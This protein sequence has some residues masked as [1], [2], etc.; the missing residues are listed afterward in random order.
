MLENVNIMCAFMIIS[1][2]G[3]NWTVVTILI[4]NRNGDSICCDL[5][6]DLPISAV[7]HMGWLI[8]LAFCCTL[9]LSSPFTDQ[10]YRWLL[11]AIR[12]CVADVTAFIVTM[13]YWFRMT[14]A[15]GK[16]P[17]KR[18]GAGEGEILNANS[19]DNFHPNPLRSAHFASGYC[20]AICCVSSL[21]NYTAKQTWSL[22]QMPS[23]SLCP[24]NSTLLGFFS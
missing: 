20:L 1:C 15:T 21:L 6:T 22:C 7:A 5:P 10:G 24:S 4:G 12:C 18:P 19:S 16:N 23:P 3:Q 8:P 11:S 2:Q 14:T 9:F 17:S 13:I